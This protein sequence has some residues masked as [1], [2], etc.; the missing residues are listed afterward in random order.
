MRVC[1]PKTLTER[2]CFGTGGFA[3]RRLLIMVVAVALCLLAAGLIGHNSRGV[4]SLRKYKAQLRAQGEKLT[5]A[6]LAPAAETNGESLE[7]LKTVGNSLGGAKLSPGNLILMT[8][9]APSA[10]R[11]AW[12]QDSPLWVN[13]TPPGAAVAWE[14]FDQ[15][16]DQVADTLA[17]LRLALAHPPSTSGIRFTN[18]L[19]QPF[20]NYM[21]VRL[22][23]QWLAGDVIHQLRQNR[24]EESLQDLEALAASA[25]VHRDDPTMVAQMIRVAVTG[26][27]LETTW[28]ALQAPGWTDAQLHRLQKAWEPV[29]LMDALER[30]VVGVRAERDKIWT[31]VRKGAGGRQLRSLFVLSPSTNLNFKDFV[32]DNVIFP[33]YKLTSLDEDELFCLE[34]IQDT[35]ETVRR[36]KKGSPWNEVS[37]GLTQSYAR[38]DKVSS[39]FLRYR[40][41]IALM[42][43]PNFSRAVQV[44]TRNETLRQMALTAIALKRYQ[45]QHSCLPVNLSA[46][47]PEFLAIPTYDPLAGRP[48]QYVLRQDGTYLLYSVGQNGIDDGGETPFWYKGKY[49]LW[50]EPDA[51]WPAA[52][53]KQILTVQEQP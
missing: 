49:G 33:V 7:I 13:G 51:V 21:H 31:M 18:L 11:V 19:Q 29:D 2:Y 34:T 27:G 24:L 17:L 43:L 35:I 8:Y 22:T 10:A 47:T 50:D 37:N 12:K 52:E 36:I 1:S 14:E 9:V 23:A 26:L 25:Q 20:P 40:H 4:R 39:S 5:M 38:L 32:S 53:A 6:E 42:A 3:S 41:C 15:K 16:L 45:I 28:E 48:L 44:G 46:L 30:G